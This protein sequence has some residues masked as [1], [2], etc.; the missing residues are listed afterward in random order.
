[1]LKE[2]LL[3]AIRHCRTIDMDNYMLARNNAGGNVA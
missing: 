3:Y 2:R 1:M